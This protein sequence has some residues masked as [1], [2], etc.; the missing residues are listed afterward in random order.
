VT[1]KK[2]GYLLSSTNSKIIDDDDFQSARKQVILGYSLLIPFAVAIFGGYHLFSIYFP[3]KPNFVL[4]ASLFY[5][6]IIIFFD[7]ALIFGLSFSNKS[8]K[9]ISFRIILAMIIGSAVAVTTSISLN[10][11]YINETYKARVENQNSIKIDTL[12][13]QI[14]RLEDEIRKKENQYLPSINKKIEK[15]NLQKEIRNIKIENRRSNT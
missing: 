12:S 4:L 10:K 8:L 15:S 1:L 6:L 14:Q 7:F 11:S 2:I 5:A 13:F 9:I 3:E